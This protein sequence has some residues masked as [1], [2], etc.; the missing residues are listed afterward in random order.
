MKARILDP[1]GRTLLSD[2]LRPPRGYDLDVAVGTTYSLGLDTLLLVPFMIASRGTRDADA[3]TASHSPA[4]MLA[5]LRRYANRIT[6]FAQAGNIHV[7][8][9]FRDF[10]TFLED[11]VVQVT[12]PR[13]DRIFHPKI[14]VLRFEAPHGEPRVLHRFVCSSRNITADPAWDTILT[15][16]EVVDTDDPSAVLDAGPLA[17]FLDSLMHF[18]GSGE[19]MTREHRDQ[20]R[21]LIDS[22]RTIRG[23]EI[24]APFEGGRLMPLGL[25]GAD[26]GAQ[27]PIPKEPADW[28]VVSPFLDGGA[29]ARLPQRGSTHLV[30][31]RPD[32]LDHVQT[33]L[34]PSSNPPT[35]M[36][37][38][39]SSELEDDSGESREGLHAKLLV[40]SEWG[41]LEPGRS[42]RS[43]V[44]HLLT[45]SANCTTAAWDGNVEFAVEL[46]RRQ[47][48]HPWVDEVIG[49]DSPLANVLV[50]YRAEP[51]DP[52]DAR[53]AEA[54]R[55][56]QREVEQAVARA[57]L[58]RPQ[59][60]VEQVA[61]AERADADGLLPRTDPPDVTDGL[62]TLTLAPTEELLD[63]DRS[64]WET[65]VR[66]LSRPAEAALRLDRRVSAEAATLT[67]TVDSDAQITPWIVVTVSAAAV[68]GMPVPQSPGA[69][70]SVSRVIKADLV[71]GNGIR[72]DREDLVLRRLLSDKELILRYVAMLIGASDPEAEQGGVALVG[73]TTPERAAGAGSAGA[74]TA[75]AL[76][77]SLLHVAESDPVQ[78][79]R[80]GAELDAL[81]AGGTDSDLADLRDIWQAL[82]PFAR[83]ATEVGHARG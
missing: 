34:G 46:W 1:T 64:G 68:P 73:A 54:R 61:A 39:S 42:R 44:G 38:N 22:L 75:P 69:A 58:S 35:P 59:I 77:E 82:A 17:E 2:A 11:T 72:A 16:D 60:H 32:T 63:L 47:G 41:D 74:P 25:P 57:A 36:M 19:G 24:P 27:W 14:W 3:E 67:W 49:K 50:D 8:A 83:S 7:P 30:V 62:L 71:L 65:T 12:A 53:A 20:V 18:P 81:T 70:L 5:S 6:V 37:M 29:L 48:L 26:L 40:W 4:E 23:F 13:R 10:H 80:V 56:L 43:R 51:L 76:L 15:C 33:L 55:A 9:A 45:G 21:T 52:A 78:L 31:S 79:A 28:A 66:P